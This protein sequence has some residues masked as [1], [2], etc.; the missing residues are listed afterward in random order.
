MQDNEESNHNYQ[1]D[2]QTQ[3]KFDECDFSEGSPEE[4]VEQGLMS[5]KRRNRLVSKRIFLCEKVPKKDSLENYINKCLYSYDYEKFKKLYELYS[6][7]N[8]RQY[9]SLIRSLCFENK[10]NYLCP[11]FNFDVPCL[12]PLSFSSYFSDFFL[13]NNIIASLNSAVY[14]ADNSTV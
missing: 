3:Q 8:N 4:G 6:N 11:Q 7:K 13:A 12:F 2:E 9:Q 14:N 1:I 10:A 5:Y